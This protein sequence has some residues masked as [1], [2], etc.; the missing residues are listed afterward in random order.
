MNKPLDLNS[1]R[2]HKARL[3]KAIGQTGYILLM[4]ISLLLAATAIFLGVVYAPRWAFIAGTFGVIFL[5][6]ALWYQG[7]LKQLPPEGNSPADR[8]SGDFY[9]LL[10]K[11][12]S[13]DPK[14]VWG[15]I[16]GHWQTKFLLSHLL[17]TPDMVSENL[18]TDVAQFSFDLSLAAQL[19][20][21]NGSSQIDVLF[22]A[23]A[24]MNNSLSLKQQLPKLKLSGADILSVANW[25]GRNWSDTEVKHT[26][27]GIG[28][29]WAFGFTPLLDRLGLNLSQIVVNR[30][31]NF[32]W[33]MNSPGVG[34][35][36]SAFASG[37]SAVVLVGDV[38]IGKTQSVFALAQKLI[39]GKTVKQLAY[40][41]IVMLNATDIASRVRRSGELER[42]I[43]DLFNEAAHASHII[44]FL[45]DAQLFLNDAAGAF[46]AGQI[47]LSIIQAH[48]VPIIIALT[49]AD[50]QR[51]K[52]ANSS[53]AGL[54][55]PVILQ[56]M[57]EASVMHVLEDN[58]LGMQ[59]KN[60]VLITFEALRE[61]YRL[62][63]RYEQV[64]AYPGKALK[65]LEQSI[66]HS[67]QG[68][69]TADSI[70]AAIEQT[71][72]VKVSS[73]SAPE[74]DRLLNLEAEIHKRMIN[75]NHAVSAVAAALRRARAGVNNPRR[76]I[77]SFLFLGP[78]GV[79]K[80]ELAKA[81][82]AT[83]FGHESSIIRLDMSEYGGDG[84]VQRLL[85]SGQDKAASLILSV[86]QNPF[87][88]VLLDEIEK[89][90]S[91]VLNLLL[92]LLDEG[93]LTDSDGRATSFKDS[94]II[95][96]S[97]ALAQRIRERVANGENLD[98]L[99]DSLTDELISS[100]QF[101]PELLNR[102]DEMV[103]FR[104]LNE[105]EL[106]QVV[107]LM[108]AEVNSTLANQNISLE[109]SDD[110]VAKIVSQGN[111]PRLGAR[112]MRRVLQRSVENSVAKRILKGEAKPGDH[113]L[114]TANDLDTSE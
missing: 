111:D 32:S 44:L 46:D 33:L 60:K 39:E 61:A 15:A 20:D 86:R 5:L 43:I 47:L 101:K 18:S 82:A 72:G 4:S 68:V 23:S 10:G 59:A 53:L 42:M 29:N 95:A 52:S 31:A 87:S 85:S 28:R 114:L 37:S 30:G 94:I 8:L 79:G 19:A 113:L 58:A 41:E 106:T 56:E 96:T 99:S 100:G 112:P 66:A 105:T 49:P 12:T 74:A 110:A 48:A 91:S 45:D 36:E 93:N 1:P 81:V 102:F 69:V 104:S 25:L 17:L 73:A 89:A 75:Q 34:A 98:N 78:T 64:E 83:Y 2:A 67:D 35:V 80:T 13:L 26:Y 22:V 71:R 21:S 38:G 7:E 57:D 90:H 70:A 54:L 6:P 92:Q 103:Y 76:P 63:G 65:L 27:G 88:V 55:T 84:D 51:L 109:L 9:V 16:A 62:S 107:R 97:N 108:L 24:M 40:H 50:F 11:H 14:S 3:A 77:G